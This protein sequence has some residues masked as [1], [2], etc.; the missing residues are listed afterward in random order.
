MVDKKSLRK[1]VFEYVK[2]K[3]RSEIEYLWASSPNCAVFR[4]FD[5]RKWY[6]IVMDVT[7]DK[8]GLKSKDKVDVLNV[9]LSNFVIHSLLEQKG[10]YPA[11]HMNKEYWISILLDGT[12]KF[13]EIC[14][15]IDMSYDLTNSKKK[16]SKLA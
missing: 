9:K 7:Y 10:F 4:H 1:D 6:G 5:N 2:E 16:A 11:Y 8:F 12:V 3:Y 13:D 14:A 15:L